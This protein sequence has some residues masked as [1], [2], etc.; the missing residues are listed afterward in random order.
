MMQGV[1]M[2]M[3]NCNNELDLCSPLY[4]EELNGCSGD[5]NG[6]PGD[7]FYRYVVIFNHARI[8]EFGI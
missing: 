3:L 4:E 7:F 1:L 2:L 6:S 8:I 5:R